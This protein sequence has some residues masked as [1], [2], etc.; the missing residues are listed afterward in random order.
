MADPV[1]P[2]I[3]IPEFKPVTVN[4]DIDKTAGHNA[5]LTCG[6]QSVSRMS[7]DTVTISKSRVGSEAAI[8]FKFNSEV[9]GWLG[10]PVNYMTCVNEHIPLESWDSTSPYD[11]YWAVESEKLFAVLNGELFA[12]YSPSDESAEVRVRAILHTALWCA[13]GELKDVLTAFDNTK[14]QSVG[15]LMSH[16]DDMFVPIQ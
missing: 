14:L 5:T 8:K 13:G 7:F 1:K 9:P 16:S 12:L 2:V 10:R 15:M 6:D 3:R 11:V 4:V